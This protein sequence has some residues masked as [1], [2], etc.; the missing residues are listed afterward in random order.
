MGQPTGRP[1]V[2]IRYVDPPPQGGST[3]TTLR[4]VEPCS[5]LKTQVKVDDIPPPT[6]PST[7]LPKGVPK[8]SIQNKENQPSNPKVSELMQKYLEKRSSPQPIKKVDKIST[9]KTS[10]PKIAKKP[11]L[12]NIN[13]EKGNLRKY[14]TTSSSENMKILKNF[15]QKSAEGTHLHLPP[16]PLCSKPP[17][18]TTE[19]NENTPRSSKF[20]SLGIRREEKF[21]KIDTV[22]SGGEKICN[23]F[24]SKMNFF[25]NLQSSATSLGNKNILKQNQQNKF[26]KESETSEDKLTSYVNN[27]GWECWT[28]GNLEAGCVDQWEEG[29][30]R[31]DRPGDEI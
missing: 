11:K 8:R 14:L 18:M 16:T 7:P 19:K 17:K 6:L 12:K 13:F 15:K 2:Q 29:R 30:I 31:L 22:G 26:L 10:S 9:S 25:Q 28:N 20:A 3:G 27:P 1:R 5:G 21:Q 4:N 24:S 23:T